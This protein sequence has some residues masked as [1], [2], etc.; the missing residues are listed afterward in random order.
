MN[1]E[2]SKALIEHCSTCFLALKGLINRLQKISKLNIFGNLLHK[3]SH[4][5]MKKIL[6]NFEDFL[7][8]IFSNILPKAIP[9]AGRYNS[10]YAICTQQEFF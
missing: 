1:N 9:K 8:N 3:P 5:N 7:K 4:N 2:L 6:K 10:C